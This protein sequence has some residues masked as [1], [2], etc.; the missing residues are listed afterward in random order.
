MVIFAIE[1][2]FFIALAFGFGCFFGCGLKRRAAA[3]MD[4]SNAAA[5]AGVPERENR[6]S[7]TGIWELGASAAPDV[8]DRGRDEPV[9]GGEPPAQITSDPASGP[10]RTEA[11]ANRRLNSNRTATDARGTKPGSAKAAGTTGK[12]RAGKRPAS[13]PKAA[14][15]GIVADGGPDNLQK[16]KG[17][18]PV[19]EAKLNAAGITSFTQ[20]AGWSRK[21]QAVFGEQLSFPGR[22]ERE[23]W[24]RQ[25]K[26]LAK[27]G[28]TDFS[29]RTAKDEA[30]GSAS[31]KRKPIPKNTQ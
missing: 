5:T 21:Q 3:S 8:T 4:S 9:A 16:I 2:V 15:A 13:K 17:V 24:V 7:R 28:A 18:G 12:A 1:V 14:G 31:P 29:K 26:V 22:I 23:D 25:A 6:R 27:G 20:I 19:I 11:M 30:A 10:A